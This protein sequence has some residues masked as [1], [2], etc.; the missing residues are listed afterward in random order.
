M[1]IL[2]QIYVAPPDIYPNVQ[3]WFQIQPWILA[4]ATPVWG[5]RVLGRAVE[6]LLLQ[7]NRAPPKI[8][9]SPRVK[10]LLKH[11][12]ST[13]PSS[14]LEIENRTSNWKPNWNWAWNWDLNFKQE[15]RPLASNILPYAKSIQHDHCSSGQAGLP[16]MRLVKCLG[17]NSH[18]CDL[19]WTF[20]SFP[21]VANWLLFLSDSL[22]FVCHLSE[23]KPILCLASWQEKQLERFYEVDPECPQR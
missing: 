11:T 18:L 5:V 22:N 1:F 21:F 8:V 3:S 23:L 6:F 16:T 13:A 17:I 4:A 15:Q 10:L 14:P 2:V 7:I 9:P 20:T 12:P 19:P